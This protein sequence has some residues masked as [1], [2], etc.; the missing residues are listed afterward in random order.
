[1]RLAVIVVLALVAAPALAT[2]YVAGS[3][4]GWDAGSAVYAMTETAPGSGVFAITLDATGRQE[5]KITQGDWSWNWPQS[6][7]SW[8]QNAAG[9]ITISYDSNTYA[10][11]WV[12]DSQRIGLSEQPGQWTAVGDWQGW[13]NASAATAMVEV[14]PG[15]GIYKYAQTFV[16]GWY[17]YK[18]VN[19][20]AWDAIGADARS[21]NADTYWFEATAASNYVEMYVN[22]FAGTI[23][24]DITPEPA[25]LLSLG[26]LALVLRRR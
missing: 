16:P 5:F 6:G 10:D 13:D 26:L 11:G 15:S 24:V 3:M 23:R 4:N 7:N 1:M 17:Q 14:A 12:T 2:Y 8:Y 9:T 22:A 20:G 25:S 18:A 19:T 21:I